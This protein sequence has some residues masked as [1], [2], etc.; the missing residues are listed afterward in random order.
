MVWQYGI[1]TVAHETT[2]EECGKTIAVLGNGFN[3]IFPKEN[4]KLYK[5]II[6]NSGLIISEYSLEQKASS[7]KFLE[8]NRIVSGIALG[9]L[10]IESAHRSGTSVTA[11]LAKEQKRK[12]FAIPHNIDDLHGVGNNRLIQ[13]NIAQLVS[14]TED[15]MQEFPELIYKKYENNKKNISNKNNAKNVDKK[16]DNETKRKVCKN[17]EYNEIYELIEKEICTINE[18]SK[19]TKKEISEINKILIMLEIEGFI[20]KIAGGYRCI[21]SK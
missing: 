9:V 11:K 7:E 15:I 16:I 1:D 20:E 3:H 17:K 13:S 19:K 4:K 10:V 8:R 14:S 18:I 12:V 5:K 2:L 6:D 21:A